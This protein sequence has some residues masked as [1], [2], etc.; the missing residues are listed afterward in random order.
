MI[1]LRYVAIVDAGGRFEL[2][3]DRLVLLYG[4]SREVVHRELL[5]ILSDILYK[6][7]CLAVVAEYL[8]QRVLIVFIFPSGGCCPSVSRLLTTCATH[9]TLVHI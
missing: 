2:A 1:D 9:R 5:G 4:Q 8:A 7:L 6:L 3:V